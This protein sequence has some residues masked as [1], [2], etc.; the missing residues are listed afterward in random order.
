NQTVVFKIQREYAVLKDHVGHLIPLK[1]FFGKDVKLYPIIKKINHGFL[2]HIEI[3]KGKN[4]HWGKQPIIFEC[5]PYYCQSDQSNRKWYHR[6]I[7]FYRAGNIEQE[8]NKRNNNATDQ[9]NEIYV[10]IDL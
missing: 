5:Y 10:G 8:R 3:K 6:L 7:I 2:S 9:C 4:D 1:C